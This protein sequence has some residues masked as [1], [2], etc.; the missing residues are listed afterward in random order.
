MVSAATRSHISLSSVQTWQVWLEG[1]LLEQTRA[2]TTEIAACLTSVTP[3]A[4]AS[5][6][7]DLALFYGYLGHAT[8]NPADE[9][10]AL[11]YLNAAIEKVGSSSLTPA[12][13]G[14]YS[15]LGWVI[16]QLAGKLFDQQE[17]EACQ[18]I[19]EALIEYLD[20][21]PTPADFDLVS[22]LIGIGIYALAR[23]PEPNAQVCLQ[24]V[25]QRLAERAERGR[26][27]VTWFTD[28]ALLPE[29]QRKIC[30]NGYYNLGLAHGVPGV[31][32]M[33]ARASA[34]EAVREAAQELLAEAVRWL[35][36]HLGVEDGVPFFPAWI[37][38]EVRLGRNRVAWCYGDL[39]SATALLYAARCAGQ[40]GWEEVA[41]KILRHCAQNRGPQA[42]V[43]DAGLCHGAAGTAHLFN[44]IY[45]ATR[46]EIFREAAQFWYARA[47]DFRQPGIG[48]AGFGAFHPKETGP[49]EWVESIDMLNGAAGVG[50]AFLAA[51]SN[52]MP[53]WDELLLVSLPPR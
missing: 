2:A 21:L 5:T 29:W 14:G 44:R 25:V 8:G 19:D 28:A 30:P 18:V 50:L 48:G 31:I 17:T 12:L 49:G 39:G 1:S 4:P 16:T 47:F 36:A 40:A 22:G 6:L 11:S 43:R 33:L 38:P 26:E 41:L 23:L 34:V 35:L 20:E 10:T 15:Q 37:A 24:K 27:G 13:I 45:Q 42:G 3:A 9:E 7:A 51:T 32:V 52:Q 46:E 53:L